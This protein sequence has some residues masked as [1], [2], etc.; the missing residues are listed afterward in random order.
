[1]ATTA[2]RNSTKSNELKCISAL[3]HA[4]GVFAVALLG[5][6]TQAP[7]LTDRTCAVM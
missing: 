2:S 7:A 5:Y 1:M 6:L 4:P 3:S